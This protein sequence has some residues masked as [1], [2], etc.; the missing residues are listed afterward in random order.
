MKIEKYEY[1]EFYDRYIKR[2]NNTP[3][4]DLFYTNAKD[5]GDLLNGL[6]EEHSLY[7][8]EEDKW[9]LKQVFGHLIDTERIFNYRA[10][11]LAREEPKSIPGFDQDLYVMNADFDLQP[12]ESLKEQ[13]TATRE[14]TIALFSSFSEDELLRRGTI[15][16]T[17]FT[18]RATGYVIAG[19]EMHHLDI[20]QERYIPGL[21]E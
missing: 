8:Y 5:A 2:S 7:R 14:S 9:S 6:T 20:I 19:H 21:I 10:L 4:L 16:G 18:V 13:Y 17:S 3:L 11:C 1:G 12:L 15:S